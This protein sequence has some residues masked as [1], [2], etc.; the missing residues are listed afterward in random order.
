MK[1][2]NLSCANVYSSSDLLWLQ[3]GGVGSGRYMRYFEGTGQLWG[4]RQDPWRSG[5]SPSKG[6]VD[7]FIAVPESEAHRWEGP[8]GLQLGRC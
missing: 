5:M 4:R 3:E 8:L 2:L 6:R 1:V 7:I